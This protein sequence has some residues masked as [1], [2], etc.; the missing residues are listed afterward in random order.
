[1]PRDEHEATTTRRRSTDFSRSRTDFRA[2]EGAAIIKN[3]DL[4]KKERKPGD[5][6]GGKNRFYGGQKLST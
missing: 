6:F 4:R 2:R 3:S 1:M 5:F